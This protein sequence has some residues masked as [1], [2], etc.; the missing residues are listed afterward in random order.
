MTKKLDRAQQELVTRHIELARHEARKTRLDDAESEVFVIL[1]ELAS[2]WERDPESFAP[3]VR[4]VIRRQLASRLAQQ[5]LVRVTR[6]AYAK[7]RAGEEGYD[8]LVR[9]SQRCEEF[10]PASFDSELALSAEEEYLAGQHESA[11]ELRHSADV[12]TF[13]SAR[14][15]PSGDVVPLRLVAEKLGMPMA[16]VLE[17]ERL[18]LS[19]P[20]DPGTRNVAA[21]HSGPGEYGSSSI[22]SEAHTGKRASASVDG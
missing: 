20:Q 15:R 10:D 11:P 6:H 13:L 9:R 14:V 18:S 17:L 8:A 7:A 3:M 16:E 1:V 2:K 21:G 12:R 19:S 22:A 5:A 4:Y